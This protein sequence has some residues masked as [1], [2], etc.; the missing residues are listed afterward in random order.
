MKRKT[1]LVAPGPLQLERLE[2]LRL[3]LH[4]LA[5]AH[6]VGSVTAV[7]AF[8][9]DRGM[10]MSTGHASL[11]VL[12]EA[13]AG[14]HYIPERKRFRHIDFVLAGV[15]FVLAIVGLLMI[16]A[17]T[18]RS[19]AGLGEAGFV[20]KQIA[21]LLLGIVVMV[22]AA[23]M[24][25]RLI[26]VYAPIFYGGMI[27]LLILVRTPLGA[28]A[29]GAQRWFQ[30]LGFQFT[31]SEYMK[32][33]LVVMLAA[34]LSELRGSE[35]SLE[36]VLKASALAGVP[37]FLVFLQPDVGTSIVL[38][39]VLAGTLV[40]SGA[41]ARHLGLLVI[42]GL[43]LIFIALQLGVVKQYQIARVIGFLDPGSS[44]QAANYNRTQSETAVGSGGITGLGYGNG[45]QTNLDF[46]PEQHTDFIFTVVGEEF[47]F[48]GA[49][50][51]LALFG[52]LLWRAFRIALLS[53]DP[54]GTYLAAGVAS[55]LAIQIFVNVGMTI[56]IMPITGIPLPFVSYGGSSMLAGCAGIGLLLG[57]LAV[58]AA[59]GIAGYLV[60]T[61]LEAQARRHGRL[62]GV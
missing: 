9:G 41:K 47:G 45:T 3:K 51:L 40:V 38:G 30:F 2:T 54:F 35:L 1:K 15:T 20:K 17:A 12:S 19:Y 46:V 60:F 4:R 31:P 52:I 34:Y 8:I 23:A 53:K 25:Y 58:G 27:A 50:G 11:P 32:L 37:M 22:L 43:V 33:A 13:I 44:R 24:D 62:E 5:P 6:P 55:M 14:R 7:R 48:V 18:R 26:K 56:G 39:V 36:Q 28:S 16:H 10:V 59:Y 61:W 49:M 57:D 21:W 42:A 29:L